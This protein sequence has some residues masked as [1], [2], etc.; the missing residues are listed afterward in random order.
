MEFGAESFALLV[1]AIED[2]AAAG[3]SASTDAVADATAVWVALHG[4][5]TLRTALPGF[6]WPGLPAFARQLVLPLAQGDRLRRRVDARPGG[7]AV[8][9]S[10]GYEP[11]DPRGDGLDG[12][13]CAR[14][15]LARAGTAVCAASPRAALAVAFAAGMRG[16][17]R[18]SGSGP[19]AARTS[20]R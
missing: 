13:A 11:G 8:I 18:Q 7:P 1:Q 3:A 2:C 12:D 5:V 10:F 14:A 4:T 20:G 6:P 9:P 16:R 15:P 17:L 19:G